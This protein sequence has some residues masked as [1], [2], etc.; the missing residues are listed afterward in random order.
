MG[1]IQSV[2]RSLLASDL[3]Y[4]VTVVHRSC[5]VSRDYSCKAGG[6]FTMDFGKLQAFNLGEKVEQWQ[7][8][9]LPNVY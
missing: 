3:D 6:S 7:S 1:Q 8:L 4:D 2:C 9:P 5:V